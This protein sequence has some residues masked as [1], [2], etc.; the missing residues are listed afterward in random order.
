VRI[1]KLSKGWITAV[2]V[3]AV[4]AVFLTLPILP[5]SV[6]TNLRAIDPEPMETYGWPEFVD[7]V[8]QAQRAVP[9]GTP[10]LTSNY[11]EAGALTI[12]G[13]LDNVYSGQNS[14]GDWGPPPG[15][16][17]TV[18]VVGEFKADQ[19]RL[20]WQKVELIAP[21]TLPGGIKNEEI[22]NHATIFRCDQP[23]GSWAQ[24]WPRLRHLS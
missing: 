24:L 2:G 21:I 4:L 3:T 1:G 9:A 20:G 10:I 7:Q 18:L 12:L 15:T 8:K 6:Q 14:Y 13:G 16:S 22:V 11:G 17:P 23:K 19:L 5:P